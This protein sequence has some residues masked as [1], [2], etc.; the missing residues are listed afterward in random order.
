MLVYFLAKEHEEFQTT[1]LMVDYQFVCATSFLPLPVKKG[2][3]ELIT[4]RWCDLPS[5]AR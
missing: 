4:I 5:S 1:Y 2:A 3:L